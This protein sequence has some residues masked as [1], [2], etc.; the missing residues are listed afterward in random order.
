[1][2]KIDKIAALEI[3]D[4][5]GNPTVKVTLT[6]D[7]GLV[8]EASVP[9]GASTGQH[10]AH[11][12]RDGDPKRYLGKGVR[13]V[14]ENVERE[15]GPTL[16]GRD[17]TEQ[18]RIDMSMCELD[19][20]PNKS[21]LG[22]NAILGVS[23]AVA[24]AAAQAAKVPLYRYI[25]SLAGNDTDGDYVL[26]APMMNVL[27]GGRHSWNNVDFQE[28]MLFPIGAPNFS[29]A[30]RY[31]AEV[32]QH[33][34]FA[35]E[36]KKLATSVGDE[37]G[38]APNLQSNEEALDTMIFAI[39]QAGLRPGIDVMIALD[40]AASE[41]YR[42]DAYQ[43]A[44][45]GGPTRTPTRMG[46]L[47]VDLVHRYPIASIED[48][49]AETDIQGWL[50]I[51]SLLGKK[52]QLV[53]DDIFVTNSK[54]FARGIEQGIGNAILIKLNQIGTLTETLDCMALAKKAD[55]R[56]VVSHRSGETE[57]AF[58]ADLAVGTGC[59]QIKTGSLCRSERI[60]KYNRL[61]EIEHELGDKARYGGA[62]FAEKSK[63]DV[64]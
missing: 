39:K 6:L 14:V 17:V 52:I 62:T 49:M 1:M 31:G 27:N 18:R 11:E 4:S 40:P 41:F 42:D 50:L 37:G 7:N 58:I 29:E 55:Y 12:L 15:I 60:A 51:T 63:L 22:A 10:E 43:F 32:F 53:G 64:A 48:G 47:Y 13:R 30:L 35:L 45:S 19:G 24:R 33:M 34:K 25:A 56:A 21:R 5:R 23:L 61:L 36:A 54:I 16:I 26:P 3:L 59:G 38:F 2:D 46:E 57:D 8:A 28:F 20:T 9:S 44:K